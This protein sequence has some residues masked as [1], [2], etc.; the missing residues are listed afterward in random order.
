VHLTFLGNFPRLLF[1]DM[2]RVALIKLVAS[3]GRN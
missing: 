2:R 3:K 1:G